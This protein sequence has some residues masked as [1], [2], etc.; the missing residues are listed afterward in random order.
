MR[1]CWCSPT[2]VSNAVF[3]PCAQRFGQGNA[4]RKTIFELIAAELLKT[5]ALPTPDPTVH[6][7]SQHGSG[8][9]LSFIRCESVPDTLLPCQDPCYLHHQGPLH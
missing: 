2:C 9:G 1:R 6:A 5:V 7:A 3:W 8:H 4:L